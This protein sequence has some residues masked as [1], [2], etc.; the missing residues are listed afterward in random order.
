MFNYNY[1]C[2]EFEILLEVIEKSS[3]QITTF[4]DI[5]RALRERPEWRD[6]MRRLI[7]TDE[8]LM[9]PQ[10]FE[11][12]VEKEFKPLAA[13]VDKLTVDVYVIKEDVRVLKNK[14]VVLEQDVS[15]LKQDVG[16]L[17][18]DVAILKQDVAILKQDVE[19]LKRDVAALK[20]EIE[21]IKKEL[22]ILKQDV[23]DL[24]GEMFEMKV[25]FRAPAYFGRLIR[26]CRLISIEDLAE[27]LEDAVDKGLISESEKQEG[28][29]LDGV[30]RGI[31]KDLQAKEV[32]LAFE[33]SITVDLK[34][35]ERASVRADI[36]ARTYGIETIGVVLGKEVNPQASDLADQLG[37]IVL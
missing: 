9:L 17:K 4:N 1:F 15:T 7:L 16:V 31:T 30:V 10:K 20:E 27:V 23:A 25:R 6:E 26:R 11:H 5:V 8:L 32:L 33:V 36:I 28:L 37:V 3:M 19:I 24:K 2:R 34:D 12:F 13:H 14:T 18:Q 22:A 21:K 29:L 35:V